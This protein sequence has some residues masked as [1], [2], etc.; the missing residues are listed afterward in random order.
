L[1]HSERSYETKGIKLHSK[2]QETIDKSSSEKLNSIQKKSPGEE[3][4]FHINV[5]AS[6]EN[7]TRLL[8]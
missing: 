3:I 1:L 8:H 4:E 2:T 5:Y 6:V 7:E